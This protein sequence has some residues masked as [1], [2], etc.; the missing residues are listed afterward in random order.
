MKTP[1]EFKEKLK[2]LYEANAASLAGNGFLSSLRKKAF[3]AFYTAGFPTTKNEEWRFTNLAPVLSN[4][5]NCYFENTEDAI[6]ACKHW[7]KLGAYIQINRTSLLKAAHSHLRKIA[8]ALIEANC[9][10]LIASDAHRASGI[11]AWKE[12][13]GRLF[14]G[15][16]L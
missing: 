16:T 10:H 1:E 15:G 12:H 7:I 14:L 2:T 13:Q 9:V 11:S 6:K 4:D 8:C 5:Y 3:E